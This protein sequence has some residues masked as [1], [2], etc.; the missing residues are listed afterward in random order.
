MNPVPREIKYDYDQMA[1][2]FKS[3]K[4][5]APIKPIKVTEEVYKKPVGKTSRRQMFVRNTSAPTP[6]PAPK[7]P[8]PISHAPEPVQHTSKPVYEAPPAKPKKAKRQCSE[9]QRA[10][11]ARCRTKA[12]E[13]R[14]RNAELRIQGKEVPKKTR[15]KKTPVP[16]NVPAPVSAPAPAPAPAHASSAEAIFERMF[17]AREV[18]RLAEKKVRRAAKAKAKAE[19]QKQ[20]QA[21]F[22]KL[23][24]AGVVR[25]PSNKPKP[26]PKPAPAPA[27]TQSKQ[28]VKKAKL[29]NGR[30]VTVWE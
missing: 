16:T 25:V 13:T 21:K 14:R 15:K 10:H 24:K 1:Q 20:K 11:L 17:N 9:K 18:K 5:E 4:K 6:A 30:I 28:K 8:S 3:A 19:R 23:V 29:V 22:D 12:L 26:K 27:P 2:D 7:P